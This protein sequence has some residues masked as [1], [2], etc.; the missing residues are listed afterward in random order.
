MQWPMKMRFATST[1]T[2]IVSATNDAWS[3]RLSVA[4]LHAHVHDAFSHVRSTKPSPLAAFPGWG[5]HSAPRVQEPLVWPSESTC[6]LALPAWRTHGVATM[7]QGVAVEDGA[8]RGAL[9]AA[10]AGAAMG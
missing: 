3:P 5:R 10:G 4:E 6:P 7:L 2:Q 1:S 9:S 8:G